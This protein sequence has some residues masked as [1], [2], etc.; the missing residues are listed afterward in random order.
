VGDKM[1]SKI[2]GQDAAAWVGLTGGKGPTTAPSHSGGAGR[3]GAAAQPTTENK[4]VSDA[5]RTMQGLMGDLRNQLQDTN[6]AQTALAQINAKGQ[7]GIKDVAE[8]AAA[9]QAFGTTSAGARSSTDGV[10]GP[11]TRNS[12]INIKNF[13]EKANIPGTIIQEG[14]GPS[15]YKATK[16]DD[17]LQLANANIN[18]LVRLFQTVG[19]SSTVATQK[20][21]FIQVDSV[22]PELDPSGF[23]DDP[24][25]TTWGKNPVMSTDI[26]DFYKFFNFIQNLHLVGELCKPLDERGKEETN[27]RNDRNRRADDQLS[28]IEKLAKE[29]LESTIIRLGQEG[30]QVG[31]FDRAK[32][33]P[34]V[35]T[36]PTPE[37]KAQDDKWHCFYSID[38]IID[39]FVRRAN[40]I[41]AQLYPLYRSSGEN[42]RPDK[43]GT[44]VTENDMQLA[45]DYK[46]SMDTIRAQWYGIRNDVINALKEQDKQDH[47]VVTLGTI[48]GVASG[49]AGGSGGAGRGERASGTGGSGYT[50][51]GEEEQAKK[52]PIADFMKL[53]V[54]AR[55][56][57]TKA[58]D[59]LEVLSDDGLPNVDLN[60]WLNGNWQNLAEDVKGDTPTQK[61]NG[62]RNW[63]LAVKNVI[64]DIFRNWNNRDQDHD[65]S[66]TKQQTHLWQRWLDA[67]DSQIGTAGR[68]LQRTTGR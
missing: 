9:A 22:G 55:G 7:S 26:H 12:L 44:V 36:T 37:P 46:K 8:L 40:A 29:I 45:N 3:G 68:M 53:R 1:I 64:T 60:D 28:A 66:V 5:V 58:V 33:Q 48:I 51:S 59:E 41:F 43:K 62:F 65:D 57:R 47:P 11:Q 13:V 42:P 10:W 4:P 24:W 14:T 49:N 34:A 17:L 39:W 20:G 19:L 16:E 2:A 27:N 18:N 38:E 56:L 6:K 63:A 50:L 61:L 15:P 67:I 32:G 21:S 31:E 23:S 52:A 35:E 30:Q 54:L 25:P